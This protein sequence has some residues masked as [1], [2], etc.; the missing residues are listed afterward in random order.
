MKIKPQTVFAVKGLTIIMVLTLTAS[1]QAQFNYTSASGGIAITGYFGPGGAV[2]I[3]YEINGKPV[4]SIGE[5][6]FE[7]QTNINSI[8]FPPLSPI[9]GRERSTT[10]TG[11]LESRCQTPC[12]ASETT[13]SINAFN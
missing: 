13:R 10:A 4:T 2:H 9:S 1:S 8:S 5:S 12:P 3:P 7:N 11:F 6:A